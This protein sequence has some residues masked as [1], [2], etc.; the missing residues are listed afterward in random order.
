MFALGAAT[1]IFLATGA[2]DLRKGFDRLYGL[3]STHWQSDPL[4]GHLYLFCNRRR[5]A[6]KIFFWWEGARWVCAARLEK[7]TYRWPE[8]GEANVTLSASQLQLLLS[9][10]D[11]TQATQRSRWKK[12]G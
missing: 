6:L 11:L 2:T 12:V 3:I 1:Q 5:D 8:P 10:I 9:G 7:G 4:S